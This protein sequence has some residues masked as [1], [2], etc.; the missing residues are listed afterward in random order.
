MVYTAIDGTEEPVMVYIG[1]LTY[2]PPADPDSSDFWTA[3]VQVIGAAMSGEV[4]I[5][6]G[7]DS[8][9]ALY[10]ALAMAGTIVSSSMIA[11]Q[12]DFAELPNFGFP[13]LITS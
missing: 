10:S 3:S 13:V 11:S 6:A 7:A 4:N 9:Q 5:L 2:N 8:V 12:I 1:D